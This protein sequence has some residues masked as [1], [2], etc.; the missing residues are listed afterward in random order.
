M[1][2]YFMSRIMQLPPIMKEDD[3][4]S[5]L[6]L[7]ESAIQ[8]SFVLP[9]CSMSTLRSFLTPSVSSGKISLRTMLSASGVSM[10]PILCA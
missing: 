7:I 2:G 9:C 1:S 3:Q 4:T 6:L 8:G 10:G 5:P